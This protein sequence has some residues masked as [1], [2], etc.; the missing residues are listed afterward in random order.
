MATMCSKSSVAEVSRRCRGGVAEVSHLMNKTRTL[1]F[2]AWFSDSA[3]SRR[4]P[5]DTPGVAEIIV[6][7]LTPTTLL[8][9]A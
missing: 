6:K 5:C 7:L 3:I 9:Y 2:C 4:H 1:G 8:S